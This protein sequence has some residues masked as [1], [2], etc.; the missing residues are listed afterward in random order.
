MPEDE[1]LWRK[2]VESIK[3]EKCILVLGPQVSFDSNHPD[4]L[5]LSTLLAHHLADHY[6]LTKSNDF[7]NPDDLAYV[8]QLVMQEL[9]KGRSDLDMLV[10]DFYDQFQSK[11][12]EFHRD[13]AALPFTLCVN[14]SPDDLFSNALKEAGKEPVTEFYNFRLTRSYRTDTSSAQQLY[15]T[16]IPTVQQ[17]YIYHLYGHRSDFES[18]VVTEDDLLDFLVSII[19]SNSELSPLIGSQV[20]QVKNYLFVGFGFQF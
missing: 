11:T 20:N 7:T 14:T 8:A 9:R 2:L 17:P 19:K 13:L 3:R 10:R 6:R 5:P 15:R 18:L 12:T 16:H 1:R 4:Q